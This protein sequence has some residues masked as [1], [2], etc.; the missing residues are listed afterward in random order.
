MNFKKISFPFPE[1]LNAEIEAILSPIA[2]KRALGAKTIFLRAS[3]EMFGMFYIHS[4][5]TRHYVTSPGG[6]EKIMYV[7]SPGWFF[8]E[9]AF[10]MNTK[11]GLFTSAETDVELWYLSKEQVDMLLDKHAEIRNTIMSCL[12]YKVLFLRHETESLCFNSCEDRLMRTICM[13][14]D[15]ETVIDGKWYGLKI[16]YTHYDLGVLIGSVRVT[17]SKII[18]KLCNEGI[19]RLINH[20]IQINVES[21]HGYMIRFFE[22]YLF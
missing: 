7:L 12:T 15:Q 19:L 20:K 21:Y 13:C 4:G 5:S 3:D 22:Q 18:G 14:V 16:Q 11:T 8:G 10:F 9:P 1:I 17:V 6:I 2:Q